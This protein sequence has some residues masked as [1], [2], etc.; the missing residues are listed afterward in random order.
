[1]V[2]AEADPFA[3]FQTESPAA[4]AETIARCDKPDLVVR[5][6]YQ[7]SE[8]RTYVI[9]RAADIAA[10]FRRDPAEL[11]WWISPWPDPLEVIEIW[12]GGNDNDTPI[13][14]KTRARM[15][16]RALAVVLAVLGDLLVWRTRYGDGGRVLAMNITIA[17]LG[18]ALPPAV[19]WFWQWAMRRQ[20]ARLTELSAIDYVARY[21][22][23]ASAKN[24]ARMPWALY[25]LHRSFNDLL[26]QDGEP[27]TFPWPEIFP[28]RLDRRRRWSA[29]L[30][31][32]D[33]ARDVCYYRIKIFKRT[34]LEKTFMAE[35]PADFRALEPA[36]RFRAVKGRLA[37][38]AA[39]GKS[40]TTFVGAITAEG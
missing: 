30:D 18:L 12:A 40:N 34:R 16:G 15:M 14:D 26:P 23:K 8:H 22:V 20:I 35:I 39:A 17:V 10:T 37:P 3:K 27:D 1:M 25:L 31:T 5:I 32:Y 11:A 19:R 13:K 9:G 36:E 21:L 24:P 29:L 28:I 7:C 4:I 38:I 2:A 33:P 6:A